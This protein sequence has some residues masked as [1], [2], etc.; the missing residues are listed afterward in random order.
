MAPR[1]IV[2]AAGQLREPWPLRRLSIAA[3]REFN[4]GR[5]FEAHEIIE[6]GLETVPDPLWDL[7]VGLI[8]IAVGYHKVTHQLWSGAA[9][10]LGLGLKKIEPFA[11]TAGAVDVEGLRA[12]V[13]EDVSALR[14]GSFDP[15]RFRQRPP[16]LRPLFRAGDAS[17]KPR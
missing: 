17:A 14:S 7:F 15:H 8:Q 10:M 16:R 6:D 13:R 5:Y 9:R 4:A 12:R 1:P 3:A 2:D 11:P